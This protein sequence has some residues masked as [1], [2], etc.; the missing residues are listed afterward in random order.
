MSTVI[1][2]RR[3]GGNEFIHSRLTKLGG[4]KDTETPPRSTGVCGCRRRCRSWCRS[5]CRCHL[6]G[7]LRHGHR[8][9]RGS[10]NSPWQSGRGGWW[11]SWT[12][13]W[14]RSCSS[15]NGAGSVAKEVKHCKGSNVGN[16]AGSW[17][18]N[19]SSPHRH[20]RSWSNTR[21][22]GRRSRCWV[23]L[24]DVDEILKILVHSLR[25]S[26]SE[27]KVSLFFLLLL[28]SSLAIRVEVNQEDSV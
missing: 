21:T 25:R 14:C 5:R 23:A 20:N 27:L 1:H 10:W 28:S 11:R 22:D 26:L 2:Q 8:W 7:A 15:R 12:G 9:A 17:V 18:G 24:K 19:G 13:G 16:G 3:V 4:G 6:R